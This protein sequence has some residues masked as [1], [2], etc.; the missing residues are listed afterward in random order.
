M[1]NLLFMYI[2]L[3]ILFV[4]CAKKGETQDWAKIDADHKALCAD[5]EEKGYPDIYMVKDGKSSLVF[6]GTPELGVGMHQITQEGLYVLKKLNIRFVRNTLY[7][8]LME[9]KDGKINEEYLKEFKTAM[10]LMHKEGFIPLIVVHQ[11]PEGLSFK[12][13]EEAYSKFA[14]F[15]TWC[16]KEFPTVRYWQLWNE[17]D[18][19]FTDLFGAFNKKEDGSEYSMIERAEFYVDMLKIA[20]PAIKK[21]NPKAIVVCGPG[22]T[23]GEFQE[24]IYK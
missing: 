23:S 11:A 22:A 9:D 21:A 7:W 17:M 16:A 18:V 20:F 8:G 10:N 2:I 13:R 5:L 4:G 15:M 1:K 3:A 12:N 19:A 14:K 24:G 6:D